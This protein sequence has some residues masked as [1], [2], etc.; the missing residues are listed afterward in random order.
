MR[1]ATQTRVIY[2]NRL[3][4]N[5]IN[6]ICKGLQ[7]SDKQIEESPSHPPSPPFILHY[8]TSDSEEEATHQD[9]AGEIQQ[10]EQLLNP[11][12][13]SPEFVLRYD[14]SISDEETTHHEQSEEPIQNQSQ[15]NSEKEDEVSIIISHFIYL[16]LCINIEEGIWRKEKIDRC[17]TWKKKESKNRH[18]HNT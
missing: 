3:N 17:Q 11:P 15:S 6:S 1:K 18:Q 2:P 5:I 4:I 7:P 9:M 16:H 13:S 14:P 10:N 8:D 12:P